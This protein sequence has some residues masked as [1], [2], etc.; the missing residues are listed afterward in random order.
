M[1]KKMQKFISMLLVVIFV[2]CK[3][4]YFTTYAEE[5]QEQ[6]EE[7]VTEDNET[8]LNGIYETKDQ[9]YSISVD[10]PE[11]ANIPSDSELYLKQLETKKY[12]K[13][14]EDFYKWRRIYWDLSTKTHRG[15]TS[16][17]F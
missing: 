10:I 11:E 16:C 7:I 13:K 14:T 1:Y 3:V 4:L 17:L 6:T 12:E 5:K 15:E 2:F 9:D 8:Y